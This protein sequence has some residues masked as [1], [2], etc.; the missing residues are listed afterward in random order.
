[1][2][3]SGERLDDLGRGLFLIQDPKLFCFGIDAVL[4]SSYAKVRRN[5]TVVDLCSGNGIIP[6]LLSK[7]TSAKELIGIEIQKAP[8]DMAVRSVDYNR[9]SD[10][11]KMLNADIRELDRIIPGFK[12]DVITVNPPYM[13]SNAGAGNDR[14]ELRVARFEEECTLKDVLYASKKLLKEKGRLYMVHRPLRLVEIFKTMS[15]YGIEPK[16]MRLVQ[17]FA[18]EEPNLVLIEGVLGAGSELRVEAPLVIY[19]SP[20][21][22]TKEVRSWYGYE[23]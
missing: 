2:L 4:L 7:K 20:G 1:M 10:R 22:Y 19:D 5:E 23:Q 3:N 12:A 18:G 13:K 6:I 21:N 17:P 16:K 14:K 11:V 9:L 8:C 15:D